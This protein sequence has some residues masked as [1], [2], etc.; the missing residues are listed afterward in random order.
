MK[1][2][3]IVV[4]VAVTAVAI[5]FVVNQQLTTATI[6]VGPTPIVGIDFGVETPQ[7]DPI[8]MKKGETKIIPL[9]I[10][11]PR[12]KPLNLKVGVVGEND[13]TLFILT[14]QQKLPAGISVILDKNNV[15]LPVET[16]PSN[17]PRDQ[18]Q[19]TLSVSPSIKTGLHTLGIVLVTDDQGTGHPAS[20]TKYLRI[21]VQE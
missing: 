10:M 18:I 13:D 2:P 17:L 3:L 15:N 20:V 14:G 7:E 12:D 5:G 16:V 11:A 4:I 1:I 8:M 9:N 21:Q 19:M 6:T